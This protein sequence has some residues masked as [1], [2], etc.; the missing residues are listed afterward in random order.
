[1][2]QDNSQAGK[3]LVLTPH[4]PDRESVAKILQGRGIRTETFDKLAPLVAALGEDTGA[5][6]MSEEALNQPD[7][8]QLV[9][10]VSEQPTWSSYPF[11]L[12]VSQRRGVGPETF[13][14]T[15]PLE[16]TNVM[17][18]ER[19]MGSATLI[20][21]V[22]WAL[23]GRQR[24][25]MTRD[26]LAALEASARQQRLMTRELAHRVKNNIAMLQSIVNQTMRPYPET[27]RLRNLI[28]ERFSALARAHDLLLS[29]DFT[30]ADFRTL[31]DRT[32]SVH[33]T[34]F[35]MAGPD[36]QL[37]PQASLSMA[38]V[39]H[40]LSTNA[41][42][43]GALSNELGHVEITWRIDPQGQFHLRWQECDG[44]PVKPV[45]STSF[46][47]R[48]ITSTLLG[49][50]TVDVQYPVSG[51]TLDFV[52][53]LEGMTYSVAPNFS[54]PVQVSGSVVNSNG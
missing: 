17:V 50:G 29:T 35:T 46:G 5:I 20:S 22:Q 47:T 1:M 14:R 12:M 11:V 37:S 7:W 28:V 39:L 36:V 52:G 42:K 49:L 31:V 33:N 3:V 45:E 38:L 2:R 15:L 44:P 23:G 30:S 32:V 6:V 25:L 4:A 24:Q 43:Y 21:A 53:P 10:A 41:V 16:I 26:H 40:E 8:S 13:Y 18:L 48:L 19:P 9:R 27:Q 34:R 51:L 54:D